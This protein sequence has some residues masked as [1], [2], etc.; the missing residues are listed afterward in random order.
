MH[1]DTI[2]L[3]AGV[4]TTSAWLPQL[5]RTWQARSADGL[6]W[7]YL[8]ILSSGIAL[9]I[10]YGVVAANAPVVIAN[11]VT[12]T[13]VSAVVG[14]KASARRRARI[15]EMANVDMPSTLHGQPAVIR[16]RGAGSALTTLRSS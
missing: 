3:V 4:L 12:F 13:L 16:C 6:S 10:T 15:V 11:S 2:G 14:I 9:W 1:L 8:A 7:S 5:L